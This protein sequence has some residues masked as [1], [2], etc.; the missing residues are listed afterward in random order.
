VDRLPNLQLLAGLANVEKQAAMPHDWLAG[1]FANQEQRAA[2]IKE[3]DLAE[4]PERIVEFM[5]FFEARKALLCARLVKALGVTGAKS[6]RDD[7]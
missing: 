5:T 4:V 3:N 6:P 7:D 1:A 2:Y